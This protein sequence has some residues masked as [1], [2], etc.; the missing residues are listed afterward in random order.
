MIRAL[1]WDLDGTIAET[2]RDGHRVAFNQAFEAAGLAWRWSVERYGELLQMTGG[3]ERLLHDMAEQVDAPPIGAERDALARRLHRLKNQ[4]YA[5]IVA[6]GGIVARPGVLRLMDE[7]AEAGVPLAVATTT[8]R[9]N[10]DALFHS[11]FGAQWPARFAALACAEDA[12]RKKPNPQVYLQVLQRLN[13]AASEVFAIEDSP[14]GLAA[15]RAAGIACGVTRSAYFAQASFV[16]AAWVRDDLNSP[17][18][19]T[20]DGLQASK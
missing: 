3:R 12:P 11:L 14:N 1:I 6:L 8:S 17:E 19:T 5:E 20:L 4:R 16:G 2:E 13:C 15:A 18:R 9:S 10:V 7:C